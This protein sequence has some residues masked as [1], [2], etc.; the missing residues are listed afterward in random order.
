M[1][2]FLTQYNAE[3]YFYILRSSLVTSCKMISEHALPG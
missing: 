2:V 1:G 3:S